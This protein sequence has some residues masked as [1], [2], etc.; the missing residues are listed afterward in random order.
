LVSLGARYDVAN[1]GSSTT[2]TQQ[3]RVDW[4][5]SAQLSLFGS[6]ARTDQFQG[7]QTFAS[8]SG[9]VTARWSLSRNFDLSLG[10]QYSRGI[11]GSLQHTASGNLSFRL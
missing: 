7:S 1:A 8:E 11:T 3:Y 2:F 9:G 4:N 5:P 10:Y 6:Y